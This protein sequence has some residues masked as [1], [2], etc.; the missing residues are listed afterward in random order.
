[1]TNRTAA[2][3]TAKANHAARTAADIANLF[4]GGREFD[5][6]EEFGYQHGWYVV[7]GFSFN[8]EDVTGVAYDPLQGGWAN[9]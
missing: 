5:A 2:L 3:E 7:D 1:M 4:H 9:A 6:L 8:I